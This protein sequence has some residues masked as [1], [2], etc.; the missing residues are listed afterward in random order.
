MPTVIRSEVSYLRDYYLFAL[1]EDI[2]NIALMEIF[3]QKFMS[4]YVLFTNPLLFTAY[5]YI[6]LF[7]HYIFYAEFKEERRILLE[8]I[9]PELQS[10][11]DDRQIEVS[12]GYTNEYYYLS[13]S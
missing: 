5:P 12:G 1:Q 8:V 10:L 7:T 9:G 2:N 4:S 13:N 6:Y 11:Y 3:L